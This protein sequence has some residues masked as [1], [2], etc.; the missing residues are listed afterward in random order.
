MTTSKLRVLTVG[1]SNHRLETFV[2]LLRQHSVTAVADVRSAPYSRF[3]PH[4]NREALQRGLKDHGIRYV[5]LG[6]ELGARSDDRSCYEN[7]RV[8]YARLALTEAF[9]NGIDR[10]LRGAGEQRIALMCAEKEPLEC[11]RTLLVAR[12][13]DERGVAVDHILPDGVVESHS[14]AMFRLLDVLG[15]PRRD[16]FHSTEELIKD[17]LARQEERIAYVDKALAADADRRTP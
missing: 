14:E 2:A 11:H 9:R 1:H 6:R 10:V 3:T 4:F 13:L 16:L 12:A 15:L 7:G 5:F 8:Q 17:A